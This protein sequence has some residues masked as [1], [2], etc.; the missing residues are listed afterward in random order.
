[1]SNSTSLSALALLYLITGIVYLLLEI[2]FLKKT[3]KIY[4]ISVTRL[5][6]AFVYGFLPAIIFYRQYLGISSLRLS[7][8]YLDIINF[9]KVFVFSIFLYILLSIGY[10]DVNLSKKNLL[11]EEC[12]ELNVT[13]EIKSIWTIC[14]FIL[15]IIGWLSLHLW[16]K[17]YGSMWEFIQN[18]N[19]IRS[20]LGEKK[21]SLAFFKEFAKVINFGFYGML[22]LTLYEKNRIKKSIF[23]IATIIGLC[24]ALIF[25]MASD[26]RISVGFTILGAVFIVV[27]YN[28]KYRNKTIKSQILI[29][30][31]ALVAAYFCIIMSDSVM[32][33]MRAEKDYVYE[34]VGM[35]DSVEKEFGFV[36]KTQQ[37]AMQMLNDS[38]IESKL[39]DDVTRAL[40][41]WLPSR[42]HPK[43][44]TSKSLW[45]YNTEILD[46]PSG[47][48]PTDILSAGIHYGGLFTLFL[49][50]L[51]YGMLLKKIDIIASKK[52]NNLLV[53]AFY[54]G[55]L[56]TFIQLVSHFQLYSIVLKFFAVFLCWV[57]YE[58]S[59]VF[60]MFF[61][62]ESEI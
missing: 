20:G 23:L 14:S 21:N 17:A 44:L 5:M 22:A 33:S 47:T 3:K 8:T 34:E 52:R 57:F 62:N 56:A 51:L 40:F 35:L 25:T 28:I 30:A 54:Y 9:Y 39:L 55:L 59:K 16:T 41:A 31:I 36:I 49:T 12:K 26:S 6:F 10:G 38:E 7:M 18:A 32:T 15:L 2:S 24:G 46:Y 13:P 37:K 43:G 42:F 53:S 50:P 61:K 60:I 11:I 48:Q 58:F 29:V 4:I 27:D 19:M 45:T 1:M